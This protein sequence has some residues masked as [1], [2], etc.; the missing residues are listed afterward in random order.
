MGLLSLEMLTACCALKT[1][2][3]FFPGPWTLLPVTGTL[4]ILFAGTRDNP[5]IRI[6]S[7]KPMVKVSDWSYSIYLWQW[8]FIVFAIF[9]LPFS[10]YAA[11]LAAAVC[12]APALFNTWEK[13][14][15]AGASQEVT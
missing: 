13:N 15:R 2:S 14:L 10:P 9:L 3:S 5:I 7:I 11:F 6:L 8:L 12:I 4:L 1:E